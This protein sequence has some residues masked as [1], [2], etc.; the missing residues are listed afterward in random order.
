MQ[1]FL[2]VFS[3]DFLGLPSEREID[4]AIDIVL[5]TNLILLLPYW[6]A[7]TKLKNQL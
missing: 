1:D 6:M 3:K 4:F 5:D 2:D 7:S